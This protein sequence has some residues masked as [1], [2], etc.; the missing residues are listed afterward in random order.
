MAQHNDL[1][2]WGESL[3]VDRLTAEGFA[4]L[5]TNW[6]MG[7]LELDIVARR[8]DTVV[9]AEVKTRSDLDVDPLESI[10]NRKIRNIVRAAEVFI[11]SRKLPHRVRFDLFA[12]N[13][14]PDNYTLE[15]LP[16][17]FH[18]PVRTYR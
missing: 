16:D 9:V 5:E 2:K 15:H 11:D 18:P 12:I 7:H 6:R 10:D 14:T 3:A 8:G 13:G 17:A 1:G 4:I